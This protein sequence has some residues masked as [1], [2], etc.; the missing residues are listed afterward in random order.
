MQ[1]TQSNDKFEIVEDSEMI[2]MQRPMGMD[3]QQRPF[4]IEA[5]DIILKNFYDY[6]DP[7]PRMTLAAGSKS[8][9]FVDAYLST[10]RFMKTLTDLSD[11]VMK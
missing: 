8:K 5:R 2:K 1:G 3:R 6:Y 10:P 11:E 9:D 7:Q 4:R